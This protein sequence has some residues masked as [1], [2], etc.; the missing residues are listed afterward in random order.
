MVEKDIRRLNPWSVD[1]RY[2]EDV[3]EA[4]HALANELGGIAAAVVV[5]AEEAREEAAEHA[6]PADLLVDQEDEE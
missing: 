3:P 4:S 6:T 2:A 5:A 1:G